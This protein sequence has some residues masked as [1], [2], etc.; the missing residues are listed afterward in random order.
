[1]MDRR[2]G[3]EST[4]KTMLALYAQ[5][6]GLLCPLLGETRDHTGRASD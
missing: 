2:T 4:G 1:M 5:K 3:E 6:V